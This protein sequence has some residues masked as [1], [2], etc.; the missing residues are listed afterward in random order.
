MAAHLMARDSRGRF[1]AGSGS[2]S[3]SSGAPAI[4]VTVDMKALARADR[5]LAGY[6][7]KPLQRR[8]Q[9]AYLEGARLMVGPMRQR[10]SAMFKGHN[11]RSSPR[12]IATIK[13][14]RPRLRTGE[15]A[16]ASVGPTAPLRFIVVRGTK[17]HSLAPNRPGKGDF[18]FIPMG[19]AV[20]IGPRMGNVYRGATVH[21]PGSSPRPFV[22]DTYRDIGGQVLDYI[23]TRTLAV[24]GESFSAF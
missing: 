13:A 22:D 20:A 5:R 1:I 4:S 15:M 24:T 3:S 12:T 10:A 19:E 7:G 21:H 23:A 8:A 17:A 6:M 16:V 11:A 2:S 9:Q 18:V 14:R